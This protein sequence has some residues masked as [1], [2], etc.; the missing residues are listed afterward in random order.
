MLFRSATLDRL[1]RVLYA[2][3]FS[4]TLS[5]SLRVGFVA[6][7]QDIANELADIKMLTSITSSQFSERLVHGLLTDGHYRKF[8]AR[9]HE[10]LGRA[11]DEVLRG[12]EKIGMPIL[13]A[14]NSGMFLWARIPGVEDSLALAE[15]TIREGYMLAPGNV[16]RPHLEPT[17]WMRFNVA[18]CEEPRVLRWLEHTAAGA[19]GRAARDAMQR[20]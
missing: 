15:R 18:I 8:L 10:R 19:N 2:R 6:C 17:P 5:G 4:K 20:P 14:P 3:S 7:R 1:N 9:L 13:R 16:F 12:F 11:R